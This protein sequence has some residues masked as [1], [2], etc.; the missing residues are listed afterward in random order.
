MNPPADERQARIEV[1]AAFR[2]AVTFD[3]HEGIS[4]HFSMLISGTADRS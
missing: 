4:K 2:V 1:A 3:F